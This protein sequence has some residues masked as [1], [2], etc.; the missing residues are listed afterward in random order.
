MEGHELAFGKDETAE[1]RPQKDSPGPVHRVGA[2]GAPVPTIFCSSFK[3]WVGVRLAEPGP[4]PL[5]TNWAD[6]CTGGMRWGTGGS[7]KE[8]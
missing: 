7:P 2:S 6:S 8:D 4:G 3:S 1:A 5:L